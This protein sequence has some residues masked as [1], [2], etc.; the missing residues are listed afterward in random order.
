MSAIKVKCINYV[1]WLCVC[2]VASDIEKNAKMLIEVTYGKEIYGRSGLNE[3]IH[4]CG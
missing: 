4:K 3:R 2:V 1:V